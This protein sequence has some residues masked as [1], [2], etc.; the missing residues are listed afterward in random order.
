[1]STIAEATGPTGGGVRETQER[2][3]AVRYVRL[4]PLLCS[5]S[6]HDTHATL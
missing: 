5:R 4:Q 2:G 3:P 1:M 6:Q